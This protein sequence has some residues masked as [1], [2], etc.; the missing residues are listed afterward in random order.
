VRVVNEQAY[1]AWI[2]DAKKKYARDDSAPATNVAA[3]VGA[4]VE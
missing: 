3:A 1:T 4:K 2:A